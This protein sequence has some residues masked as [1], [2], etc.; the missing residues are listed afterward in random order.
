LIIELDGGYH[1]LPLQQFNDAERTEWLQSK[2]Y[3]VIRFTNDDL[4]SNIDGVLNTIE[5]NLYE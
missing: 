5:E 3:K 4:F 1:Q 2:G